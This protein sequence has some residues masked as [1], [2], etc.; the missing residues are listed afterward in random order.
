MTS[1]CT[2]TLLSYLL[3]VPDL[4]IIDR[5]SCG[6]A[7]LYCSWNS[8][9]HVV[10]HIVPSLSKMDSIHGQARACSFTFDAPS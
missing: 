10:R 9:R 3:D 1:I 2:H 7:M 6:T 4:A 8:V 5:S